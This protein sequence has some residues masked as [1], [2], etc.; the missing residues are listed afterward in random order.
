MAMEKKQ[1]RKGGSLEPNKNQGKVNGS[2][3]NK[4]IT[5][6]SPNRTSE[7]PI[8]NGNGRRR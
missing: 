7:K 2:K 5:G 8:N 4:V 1:E 6:V 3:K